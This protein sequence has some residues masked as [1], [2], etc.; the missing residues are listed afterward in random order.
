[1][2]THRVESDRRWF[3][4]QEENH[5]SD[6][7]SSIDLQFKVNATTPGTQ[8]LHRGDAGSVRD[9]FGGRYLTEPTTLWPVISQCGICLLF[10]SR[11][12]KK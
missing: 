7:L 5:M 9:Q 4:S 1:V 12:K 2:E 8:T 3:R 10:F 6:V 11:Q